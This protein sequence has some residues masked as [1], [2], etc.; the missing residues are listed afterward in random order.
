[1]RAAWLSRSARTL[2]KFVTPFAVSGVHVASKSA[3]DDAD[4]WLVQL[5]AEAGRKR[6]TELGPGPGVRD[7]V[8]DQRPNAD[9][10]PTVR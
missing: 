2:W 8:A 10:I 3:V 7:V 5:R 6:C 4:H 1:M 9:R